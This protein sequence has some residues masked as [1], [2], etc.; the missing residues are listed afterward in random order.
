VKP[1]PEIPFGGPVRDPHTNILRDP[2]GSGRAVSEEQYRDIVDNLTDTWNS[3]I[4]H[5]EKT[6]AGLRNP[7]SDHEGF[8][9]C[10]ER[11]VA[12]PGEGVSC[13]YPDC[14]C[15]GSEI[16]MLSSGYAEAFQ[17]GDIIQGGRVVYRVDP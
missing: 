5:C 4:A 14:D 15:F 17:D 6:V 2:S 3:D 7:Q 8:G 10:G 12:I 11:S 16:I 13:V 9:P 1:P